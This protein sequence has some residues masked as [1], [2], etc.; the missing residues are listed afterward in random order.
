MTHILPRLLIL[1]SRKLGGDILPISRW[2]DLHLAARRLSGK[3][4]LNDSFNPRTELSKKAPPEKQSPRTSKPAQRKASV[5]WFADTCPGHCSSGLAYADY[6][7]N[8]RTIIKPD[9][10]HNRLARLNICSQG[11]CVLW[12]AVYAGLAFGADQHH[13][14]MSGFLSRPCPL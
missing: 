3:A 7:Q 13:I 14:N 5:R 2:A 6:Y 4:Q 9:V 12:P 10:I 11:Q 8:R 1:T